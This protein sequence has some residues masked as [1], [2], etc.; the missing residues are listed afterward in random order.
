MSCTGC[1]NWGI[2]TGFSENVD[3][4]NNVASG[5]IHQ[6]GIYVSN[7]ADNPV[8]RGNTCFGNA[9]CG[10]QINADGSQG[11]DGV[12]THALVEDNV[13]Y[14]NASAGGSGINFDGVQDSVVRNNLL[15][16]NHASGISLFQIDGS[17]PSMNN[18][19]ANNTI[20]MPRGSRWAFNIQ[21]GSTGNAVF[22]NVLYNAN[23]RHGAIDISADSLPG[24][25]SDYN[26]VDGRF[27]TDDGNS[28]LSP[29]DWT[30][31]TGQDAHSFVAAPAQL[32]ADPAGNDYHL[33]AG[34]PAAGAGTTTD[35]P[36]TDLDGNARVRVDIGAYAL[37]QG[38]GAGPVSLFAAA[39]A[40]TDTASTDTRPAEVGV[41]FH[42]DADG[43]VTSIR[44]YKG[45]GNTGVHNGHLWTAGGRLLARAKFKS[46]TAT[47]WQEATFATPVKITAGRTYVASY[48]A[49]AG[50]Y[51]DDAGTF[52]SAGLDVG[53]LHVD[54][55]GMN[56]PSSVFAHGKG[57]KFPSRDGAGANYWVDVVFIP[58]VPPAA[59]PSPH[60]F[61]PFATEPI[62]LTRRLLASSS[63]MP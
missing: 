62:S 48:H 28:V 57:G 10:I 18:V 13:L 55:E 52:A 46:E 8:V 17:G 15:Y 31:A 33:K 30:A 54:A 2:F 12:I 39:S 45:P 40:P 21:N 7:S 51:A 42:A 19:V 20:V 60:A 5:S 32:F 23:P 9:R 27:T 59:A 11:G 41:R 43:S 3:I 63:D 56:G 16:N 26:A 36:P 49:K 44:F 47:G 1:G 50:H 4:E 22:N 37:A 38:R 61:P 24:F 25:K 14:D 34:S 6:H 58:S 35:A 53:P 29:A